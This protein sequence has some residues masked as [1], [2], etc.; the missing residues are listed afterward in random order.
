MKKS[1]L[2]L[3][4]AACCLLSGCYPVQQQAYY[5]SPLNVHSTDYQYLM[6]IIDSA[7][8]AVYVQAAFLDGGANQE[9]FF[10]TLGVSTEIVRRI[11]NGV[12]H[13]EWGLRLASGWAKGDR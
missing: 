12:R 11:R 5:V 8:T 13:G 3:F 9:P 2:Y 10:A 6:Q 7:H 1:P 4:L